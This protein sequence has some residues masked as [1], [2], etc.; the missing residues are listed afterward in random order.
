[1][2]YMYFGTTIQN[3]NNRHKSWAIS[4]SEIAEYLSVITNI[5]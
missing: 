5:Y 3:G 1:M 4:V 2:F